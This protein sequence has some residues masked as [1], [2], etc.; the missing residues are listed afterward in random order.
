MTYLHFFQNI[1]S[2]WVPLSK[3][4]VSDVNFKQEDNTGAGNARIPSVYQV[5]DKGGGII[6]I[7]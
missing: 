6:F 2:S 5:G 3:A 4:V 1:V 7:R